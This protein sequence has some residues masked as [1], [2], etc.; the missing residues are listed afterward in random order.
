[1]VGERGPELLEFRGGERV[2]DSDATQRIVE[3]SKIVTA[4]PP[5]GPVNVSVKVTSEDVAKAMNGLQ[6]ALTVDGQQMTGYINSTVQ[7]GIGSSVSR[8]GRDS[9]YRR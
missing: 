9:Y 6:V 5:S 4:N 7:K 3:A 8:L 1:M 2:Y